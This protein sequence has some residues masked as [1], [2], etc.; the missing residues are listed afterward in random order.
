M[1]IRIHLP[2]VIGEAVRAKI[3][4]RGIHEDHVEEVV[5]DSYYPTQV[6]KAREGG[7]LLLGR[8]RGGRY[9]LLALYPSHDYAGRH[10]LATAREMTD[11]ER[12]LYARHVRKS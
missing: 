12:R 3:A 2:L 8:D 11:D 1:P 9:L 4:A 7:L 6:R 10:V 5:R